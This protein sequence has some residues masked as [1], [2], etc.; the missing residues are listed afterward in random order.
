MPFPED[1]G[2]TRDQAAAYLLDQG[3]N[4]AYAL[5]GRPIGIGRDPVNYIAIREATVS[6]FHGEVRYDPTAGSFTFHSMGAHG[7]TVNG[8]RVTESGLAL[9]EG[10]VL[11]IQGTSLRFTTARPQAPYRTVA[12]ADQVPAFPSTPTPPLPLRNV[13]PPTTGLETTDPRSL[14]SPRH[15]RTPWVIALVAVVIVAALIL[16]YLLRRHSA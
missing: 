10:D 12:R 1:E 2:V 14:S 9:S 3:S 15:R 7:S 6:R 4:R 11:G 8:T 5:G 13:E 16:L